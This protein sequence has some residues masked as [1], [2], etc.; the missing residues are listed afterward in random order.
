M[1]L[2]IYPSRARSKSAMT[3][4]P[5]LGKVNVIVVDLDKISFKFA[6]EILK[7]LILLRLLWLS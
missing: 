1:F 7:S 4:A 3:P 5:L 2:C 6:E